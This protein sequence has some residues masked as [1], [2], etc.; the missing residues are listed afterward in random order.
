MS[1]KLKKNKK[2]IPQQKMSR[3]WIFLI[4]VAALVIL[5]V[6]IFRIRAGYETLGLSPTKT[7]V[8]LTATPVSKTLPLEVS[9][10]EAAQLQA[11][12]AFVLDVR[13]QD[14]WDA[15]HVEGA[16]LI[17]LGELPNRLSELPK[18]KQ[19]IVMC[20]TGNR[21]AQGRNLLLANGFSQVTSMAGGITAWVQAG[22]P[23]VTK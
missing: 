7:P 1:R 13:E 22:L 16:T 10:A 20:K 19:I 11:D 14:E 8:V 9:P 6:F 5:A 17:P 18:D 3:F 23:T 2:T 12:G 21:S 15:G 4:A